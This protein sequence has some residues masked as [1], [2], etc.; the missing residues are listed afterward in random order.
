MLMD[1]ATSFLYYVFNALLASLAWL[2]VYT[3]L[4]VEP[5]AILGTLMAVDFIAGVHKSHAIGR[6]VTSQRMRVGLMSK[7][8]VLTIPL[9]M[10]LA[11][12]GLGANFEWIVNWSISLFI[13]SETYSIIANIY[14]SRTGKDVPEFDA[15]SA[16]LRRVRALLDDM[17]KRG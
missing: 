5:A 17:D 8:G 10:A 13:L 14:T 11:A 7:F 3:G 4:P 15:V 2:M 9:V 1:Q 6:S 16:V 12:K